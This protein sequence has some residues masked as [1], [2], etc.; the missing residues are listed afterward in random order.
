MVVSSQQAVAPRSPGVRPSGKK[1][2]PHCG[3]THGGTECWKLARKCLKSRRPHRLPLTRSR[4]QGS[5][6]S[7]SWLR[8]LAASD[9]DAKF[10]GHKPC[11]SPNPALRSYT[12]SSPTSERVRI[13]HDL[14]V[15]AEPSASSHANCT[16]PRPTLL[17][18]LTLHRYD[19]AR[20]W[21]S[22][23]RRPPRSHLRGG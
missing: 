15:H 20:N 14:L 8:I 18:V 19:A 16:T 17:E 23:E 3:R 13:S 6:P 10:S 12:G 5:W 1:E 21:T 7:T 11:R 4:R 2:C 9:V 22:D